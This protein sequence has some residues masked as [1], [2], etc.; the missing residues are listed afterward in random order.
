MITQ[1]DRNL[2]KQEKKTAKKTKS[3]ILIWSCRKRNVPLVSFFFPTC[4]KISLITLTTNI[5]L[6]F[7]KSGKKSNLVLPHNKSAFKNLAPELAYTSGG[8]IAQ[9]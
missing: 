4:H 1:T 9:W 3:S 5:Y 6:V 2:K 8:R 7:N